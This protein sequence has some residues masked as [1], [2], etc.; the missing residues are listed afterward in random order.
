V[1]A[2]RVNNLSKV[3]TQCNSGAF[4][5]LSRFL[6]FFNVFLKIFVNVFSQSV[7]VRPEVVASI[8]GERVIA[9]SSV[10]MIDPRRR[11]FHRPVTV[12]VPL[13]AVPTSRYVAAAASDLRLFCS[14]AG[15]RHRP[16][17]QT[18]FIHS[19]ILF[20]SG[21]MARISRQRHTRH[22]NTCTERKRKKKY[23]K[24]T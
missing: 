14:L 12:S 7:D 3:A 15:A 9:V 13:S 20:E 22:T 10:V 19:F 23:V 5:F 21:N 17:G 11:K 4:P 2:M 1:E 16:A 24:S 6:R 18:L 8:A